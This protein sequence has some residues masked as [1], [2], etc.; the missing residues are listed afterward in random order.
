M[1]LFFEQEYIA[2]DLCCRTGCLK[3]RSTATDYDDIA[4]L[5]YLHIFYKYRPPG[6]PGSRYSESDG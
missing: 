6:Q 2:A 1:I 4:A 5:F 3:S